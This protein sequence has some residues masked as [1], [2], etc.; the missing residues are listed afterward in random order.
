MRNSLVFAAEEEK[1][2]RCRE[3][4][5]V[6]SAARSNIKEIPQQAE[7]CVLLSATTTTTI[8][9]MHFSLMLSAAAATTTISSTQQTMRSSQIFD[10]IICTN[11]FA[12]NLATAVPMRGGIRTCCVCVCM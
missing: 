10:G 3:L 12:N 9:R 6:S 4:N 1:D 7:K 2:A 5:F 8:W 11:P